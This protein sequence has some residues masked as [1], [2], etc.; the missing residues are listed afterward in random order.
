MMAR[1][2]RNDV[3][4]A[5]AKLVLFADHYAGVSPSVARFY[6]MEA[7][8]LRDAARLPPISRAVVCTCCWTILRPETCYVSLL[9]GTGKKKKHFR[10]LASACK[11]KLKSNRAQKEN[12]IV[13]HRCLICKQRFA[14]PCT[15]D[16]PP[17]AKSNEKTRRKEVP[18]P[19]PRK[20]TAT[21]AAVH[22]LS[23]EPK[24]KVTPDTPGRKKGQVSVQSQQKLKQNGNQKLASNNSPGPNAS[25]QFVQCLKKSTNKK[26]DTKLKHNVLQNILRTERENRMKSSADC[27]RL[28][29]S[30]T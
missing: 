27:L 22:R 23:D 6:M 4:L 15:K 30:A 20:K 8:V 10:K 24:L 2:D 7:N 29:F 12:A 16:K 25:E 19:R 11:R 5:L 17:K 18:V 3:T 28:F 14:E 1:D 9:A 26:K 13:A 21:A